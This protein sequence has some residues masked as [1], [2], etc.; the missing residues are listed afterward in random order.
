MRPAIIMRFVNRK[1]KTDLLRQ[2]KK[3]RGTAVY[4]NEHLT[5]KTAEI[6]REARLLKKNGRIK[7]TW[8]RNC[9]VF[10]QLNGSTPEQAKVILVRELK[11]LG[12]F[13]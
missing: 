8:T 5:K 9:K 12:Q 11:E 1:V 6:A 2:G 3:L 13:K 4:L 10:I 7:A